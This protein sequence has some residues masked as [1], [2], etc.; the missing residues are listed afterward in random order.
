MTTNGYT[1]ATTGEK[2]TSVFPTTVTIV[3]V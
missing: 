2:L 3:L 1:I